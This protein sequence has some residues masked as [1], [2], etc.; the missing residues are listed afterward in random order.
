MSNNQIDNTNADPSTRAYWIEL[1]H[2]LGIPV[3]CI[4]F[5]ATTKLCE[6][7]DT[8]RALNIGALNPE[9]R[10][11][12]PHSAFSSY[13]ARFVEPRLEEGFQ[14]LV[15][16]PFH[17]STMEL[18]TLDGTEVDHFSLVNRRQQASRNMEALLDMMALDQGLMHPQY[19][20]DFPIGQHTTRRATTTS[21]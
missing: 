4:W 5:T 13:A 2:K 19:I 6:H 11:I 17:V 1:A 9:K 10:A 18:A 3:R 14:D 8:V 20:I 15:S 21:I 7:N 12:L 16:V